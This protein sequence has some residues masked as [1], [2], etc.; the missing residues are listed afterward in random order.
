MMIAYALAI[1]VISMLSA[2]IIDATSNAA[3]PFRLLVLAWLSPPRLKNVEGCVPS[4]PLDEENRVISPLSKPKV[5][6]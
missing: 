6:L 4:N 2:T 5:S 1:L 3:N